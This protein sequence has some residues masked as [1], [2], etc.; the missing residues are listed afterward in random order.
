[1]QTTIVNLDDLVPNNHHYRKLLNICDFHSLVKNELSSIKNNQTGGRGGYE[2]VQLFK[3]LVLQFMENLS[4]REMDRFLNENIAGKYFCGFDLCDKTPDYTLLCKIRKKIGTDK[5]A[6]I[7]ERIRN[8]LKQNGLMS[9]VFTFIDS[10]SL[11]SKFSLWI[12]QR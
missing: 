9:E 2:V 11:I 5:L 7:F 3:C 8:C 4:D 1:M 10:S 6:T 12:D